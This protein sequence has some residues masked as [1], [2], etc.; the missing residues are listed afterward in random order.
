MK[1]IVI[2]IAMLA[3]FGRWCCARR[4]GEMSRREERRYPCETCG[5][6]LQCDEN[7]GRRVGPGE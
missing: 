2:A 6:R 1:Y 4:A 3:A 5:C 7:C